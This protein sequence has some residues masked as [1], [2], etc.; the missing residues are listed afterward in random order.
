MDPP[1]TDHAGPVACLQPEQELVLGRQSRHCDGVP[2]AALQNA[3]FVAGR[4]PGHVS[5][6]LLCTRVECTVSVQCTQ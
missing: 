1:L 4:S 2:L 3:V 5:G 6:A